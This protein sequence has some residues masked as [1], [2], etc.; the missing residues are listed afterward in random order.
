MK[1]WP[2]RIHKKHQKTVLRCPDCGSDGS[3]AL[4]A[5]C[6][7]PCETCEEAG[8]IKLSVEERD[9]LQWKDH[10]VEL[11]K[12]E[13]IHTE[14]TRMQLFTLLGV[15]NATSY[16][17]MAMPDPFFWKYGGIEFNWLPSKK[18]VCGGLRLVIYAKDAEHHERLL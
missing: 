1:P 5:F 16:T 8:W 15:P 3:H 6:C 2:D 17:T 9:T 12:N 7:I 10:I 4:G 14:M 11:I 13:S 18:G